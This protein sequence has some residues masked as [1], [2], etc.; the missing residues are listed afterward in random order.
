MSIKPLADRV[1]IEPTAA[2][3]KT[4]SGIYIPDNAKEKP[5]QGKV[6]AI[7]ND[8]DITVKVGDTV[9]YAK[10]AGTNISHQGTDYLIMPESEIL[11]II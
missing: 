9:I 8:D 1:L 2:E 10:F 5:S 7:G 6:I 3:T 4:A 11:A